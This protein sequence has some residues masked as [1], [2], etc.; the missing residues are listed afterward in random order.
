MAAAAGAE[1][2]R[3]ILEPAVAAQGLVLDDVEIHRAGARSTVVVSLDLP[4]DDE[5]ELDLDRVSDA[6]RAVSD[7]LDA[8]DVIAGH[9]TLE[10]GTRGVARP[11]TERRH[12]VR[13]VG[14]TVTVQLA[15]ATTVA[16]RLTEVV[17][18]E[19]V[20]VPVKPGLKG[21]RPTVGEPV[22]LSLTDVRD[23]RVEVDLTGLG[24]VDDE[25]GAD[26]GQES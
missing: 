21:R 3:E 6:T 8:A 5:G 26:A 19:I 20:V 23:A 18:G 11:L 13:A 24:P 4:E 9:Y 10:V 25:A 7:A 1:Q 15:D 2:V 22:R 17:D 12:F 14:R 16:G